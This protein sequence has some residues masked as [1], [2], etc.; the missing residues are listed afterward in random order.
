MRHGREHGAGDRFT[1]PGAVGGKRRKP[2][3]RQM[4]VDEIYRGKKEKFLTVVCNL[5]T[6]R[7]IVV[8]QGAEEGD[9]G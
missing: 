2:P 3:L 4:G 6:A 7:A 9:V 5:E 1:V 8:W